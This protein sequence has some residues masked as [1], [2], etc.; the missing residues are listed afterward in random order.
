MNGE[1]GKDPEEQQGG[2]ERAHEAEA[3]LGQAAP[4][5][6]GPS[7]AEQL[8]EALREKEQFKRLA[9]RSQADLVN[10]RNRVRT[11]QE[12]LQARTARRVA[13]RFIEVADQMEKALAPQATDGVDR[14]WIEGVKAIY[15]NL[16]SALAAEGLQRFEAVGE[17]F[18][19]R[20]HEALMTTPSADHKPNTVIRQ[21][22]AGYAKGSEVVRPAQVEIAASPPAHQAEAGET[23]NR[24]S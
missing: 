7:L 4:A 3:E 21:F 13:V 5:S 12:D 18:D 23:G 14:N 22:T 24:K 2:A 20:R 6:S 9:Q 10:Y 16:L 15:Q 8:E 11:E 1:T 17:E 19:P